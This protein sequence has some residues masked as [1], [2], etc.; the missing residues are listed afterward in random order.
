[1][2]IS[3]ENAANC[4]GFFQKIRTFALLLRLWRNW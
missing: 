4:A 3:E 2:L 1:M